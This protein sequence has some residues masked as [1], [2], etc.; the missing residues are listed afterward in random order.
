MVVLM[1]NSSVSNKI[2][3]VHELLN[4]TEQTWHCKI[5]TVQFQMFFKSVW[6]CGRARSKALHI[7][8][9]IYRVGT[10]SRLNAPQNVHKIQL[11]F[12]TKPIGL[13]SVK[14]SLRSRT[15]YNLMLTII[16]C[17]IYIFPNIE[18]YSRRVR[19]ACSARVCCHPLQVTDR[20][21]TQ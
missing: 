16:I 9:N 10:T 11:T 17:S 21:L 15:L 2:Q 12:C 8:Y 20:T 14:F 6:V 18:G 4:G 19:Q 3:T 7:E 1:I 13:A 5:C